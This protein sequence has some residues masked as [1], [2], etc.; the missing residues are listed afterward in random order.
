MAT[1]G[2][3]GEL[4]QVVALLGAGV[5]AVP[6]FSGS[7]SAPC[8][9]ISPPASSSAP[10]ASACSPIPR[11][12]CTSP[13]SAWS[14][15]CSSSGWRCSRRGCGAC[16]ATIFGLGA[17]QVVALRLAADRR[18]ALPP[19]RRPPSPSSPAM[20]FVLS[21]T[22]VVM[23]MLDERGET[24]TPQRPAHRVDPAAG[25]SRHRAAAGDR[26]PAGARQDAADDG[27]RALDGVAIAAGIARRARRRRPVAAQPDVPHPGGRP[28][29]RGDDGRRAP[30]RARRG[31]A[32]G[33][34]R[35]V[36]GHGRVPRRRPPVGIL[37]PP[38]ARGR[39]RAVPRHPARPVLHRRRHVARSRRRRPATGRSS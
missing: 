33:A 9:A 24:S 12:S 19:A 18:S 11:R 35:A 28:G 27:R 39:H 30:R 4:I 17:A 8:S 29:P 31:A 22:A 34:R 10:S 38:S 20:G 26:R 25:R 32:D 15:S 1:E 16:G 14:C 2:Y 13:N 5:V 37:L 23:Q 21:S 6:L 36:D 7:A 3:A